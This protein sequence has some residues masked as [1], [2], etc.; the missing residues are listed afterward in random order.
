M[1]RA[2]GPPNGT[3]LLSAPSPAK[4]A[5]GGHQETKD[6]QSRQGHRISPS[7]WCDVQAWSWGG[8]E[9]GRQ[10]GAPRHGWGVSSGWSRRPSRAAQAL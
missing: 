8:R 9:E 4:P 1:T 2:N 6:T 7:R 3:D 5:I 10:G